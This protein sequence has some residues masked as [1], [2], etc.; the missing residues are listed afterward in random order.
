LSFQGKWSI[1]IENGD[2]R[3]ALPWLGEEVEVE[4]EV[5]SFITT[6]SGFT[7]T[8]WQFVAFYQHSLPKQVS[9]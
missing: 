4:V 2:N 6:L 9:N 5:N 3:L 8:I 7:Y 1:N